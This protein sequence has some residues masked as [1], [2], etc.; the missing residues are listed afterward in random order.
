MG[1]TSYLKKTTWNEF[2]FK[3]ISANPL[4][5]FRIVWGLVMFY[6]FGRMCLWSNAVD[7]KYVNPIFHFKY[8]FFEWIEVLP[9]GMM[10]GLIYFGVILSIFTFLGLFYRFTSI[11]LFIVY[12]YVFLIDV[13][14]WNNHYYAY[15]L[16]AFFFMITNAHHAYSIDK[17]R[18]NLSDTIPAW[19]LRLFQFQ[20]I[21]IYFYG[22]LSK[23]QNHDWLNNIAGYVLIENSFIKKGWDA[24]HHIIYPFSLLITWGGIFFDLFIG[25]LILW[26]KTRWRIALP[27]VIIFNITNAIL[28]QIGSFPYTMLASFVL[29][30]PFTTNKTQTDKTLTTPIW[31]QKIII[32]SLIL[33]VAFQILFPFRSFLYEGDVIWTKEGKLCSW[34]M[35]SGS[36]FIETKFELVETNKEGLEINTETLLPKNFLTPKQTRTLGKWPF[37]V[38]QFAKFLKKEAELSGFKNVKIYGNIMVSRNKRPV[39]HLVRPD[40]DLATIEVKTFG[41]DD[42]VLIYAH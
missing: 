15:A 36:S 2:L 20:F 18:L 42:W 28:L 4:G 35:M 13:T 12:T 22:G 9:P 3:P 11:A 1:H 14:Y 8:P 21:I 6:Y 17:L 29:F 31:R 41:H 39:V 7:A 32:P 23:L 26:R 19:H 30:I 10:W 24:S 40:I 25:W 5:L 16:I 38:P 27:L 33:Y 37:L 34:H